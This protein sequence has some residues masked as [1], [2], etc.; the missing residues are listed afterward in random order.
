MAGSRLQIKGAIYQPVFAEEEFPRTIKER[1]NRIHKQKKPPT[2]VEGFVSKQQRLTE[3]NSALPEAGHW[4]APRWT[5][6]PAEGFAPSSG[7]QSPPH[8]PYP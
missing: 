8:N 3:A 2:G 6:L 5:S 1:E 4:L 7:S